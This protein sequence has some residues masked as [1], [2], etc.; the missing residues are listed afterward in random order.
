[1]WQ[2]WH[3]DTPNTPLV[4]VCPVWLRRAATA[5]CWCALLVDRECSKGSR[6]SVIHFFPTQSGHFVITGRLLKLIYYTCCI[7]FT[8][9]KFFQFLYKFIRVRL[10]KLGACLYAYKRITR[11]NAPLSW[12]SA[13]VEPHLLDKLCT[14][15]GSSRTSAKLEPPKFFNHLRLELNFWTEVQPEP[16][17]LLFSR[18]FAQALP[19]FHH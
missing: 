9:I 4:M 19:L 7:N 8:R 14:L 6:G 12:L 17:S 13:Q 3:T 1:M 10:P 16:L 11:I 5:V 18:T 15:V 2:M